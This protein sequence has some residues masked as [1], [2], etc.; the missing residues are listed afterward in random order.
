ML[1][2]V[3]MRPQGQ[4]CCLPPHTD[5]SS[6]VHATLIHAKV[7]SYYICDNAEESVQSTRKKPPKNNNTVT[8]AAF[9]TGPKRTIELYHRN[10]RIHLHCV[11]KSRR[12]AGADAANCVL[13]SA[14]AKC[15]VPLKE[16]KH[17]ARRA[18]HIGPLPRKLQLQQRNSQGNSI[19][20][21]LWLAFSAFASAAPA[22][23]P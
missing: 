20:V 3:P 2:R 10:C 14:Q 11:R 17:S 15:Q 8:R 9:T 19:F 7:G 4:C 23:R 16:G 12:T 18:T 6:L 1:Q 21:T 5:Y 22:A 13:L